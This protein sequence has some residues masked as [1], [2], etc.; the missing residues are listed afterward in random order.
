MTQGR[1]RQSVARGAVTLTVNVVSWQPS[2]R[3][4]RG[5][6]DRPCL[7]GQRTAVRRRRSPSRPARPGPRTRPRRCAEP[8]WTGAWRCRRRSTAARPS[9]RR[10]SARA[11]RPPAQDRSAGTCLTAVNTELLDLLRRASPA[12]QV[13]RADSGRTGRCNRIRPGG[14]PYPPDPVTNVRVLR[15]DRLGGLI[16]E[17]SQVA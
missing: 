5:R 2:A 13:S 17:Y 6:P 11:P 4:V 1:A 7:E 14:R 10:R 15:G 16:H 12:N 3:T 9:R 8:L